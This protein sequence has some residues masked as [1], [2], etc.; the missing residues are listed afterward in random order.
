MVETLSRREFSYNQSLSP[1]MFL[2]SVVPVI[3][4]LWEEEHHV[5]GNFKPKCNFLAIVSVHNFKRAVL[6]LQLIVLHFCVPSF[7][8]E[9]YK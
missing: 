8:F 5:Q 1:L 6:S 2:S 9:E 7:L 4:D 3:P